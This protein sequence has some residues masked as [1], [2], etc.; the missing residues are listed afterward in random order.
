MNNRLIFNQS[1]SPGILLALGL[2]CFTASA[3]ETARLSVNN[4][5][6]IPYGENKLVLVSDRQEKEGETLYLAT[7][8]VVI[9]FLDMILTCDEAVYDANTRRVTTMGETWFRR[10]RVSLTGSSAVFDPD[11]QS[12]TLYEASGYFYDTEGRSEREFFLTG[13]MVEYIQVDKIQIDWNPGK[14]D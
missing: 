3:Q 2:F 11:K 13:G 14:I 10:K 7:G 5:I 1:F 6:E 9:T 12:T 4:R 8:N